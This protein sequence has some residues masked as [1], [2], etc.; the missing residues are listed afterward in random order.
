[1][2]TALI[3][4]TEHVESILM[5]PEKEMMEVSLAIVYIDY[6][7]KEF[8]IDSQAYLRLWVIDEYDLIKGDIKY[9]DCKL[10][11]SEDADCTGV[12]YRWGDDDDEQC[13]LWHTDHQV[14]REGKQV[15]PRLLHQR[16]QV[17]PRKRL[18]R[19]PF[20]CKENDDYVWMKFAVA[21]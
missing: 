2:N 15:G 11:C 7:L 8:V 17:K 9:N 4:N 14:G 1:M 5:E 6:C 18:R 21:L 12:E 3:A 16:V 13:E 19:R 10:K 20:S